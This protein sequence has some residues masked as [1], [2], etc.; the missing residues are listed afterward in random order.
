MTRE[1]CAA[2]VPEVSDWQE[3]LD[4]AMESRA[5]SGGAL[6][7]RPGFTAQYINSLRKK[8]RGGRLPLETAQRL[9]QSLG[10]TLEWLTRGEGTKE[11]PRQSDV[12]PVHRPVETP[13]PERYPSRGEVIALLANLVEPEVLVALRAAPVETEADPGREYWV[14]YAKDLR[15]L[16]HRI[17]ADPAFLPAEDEPA[18]SERAASDAPRRAPRRAPRS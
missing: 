11:A 7:R 17:K 4:E 8:G 2:R 14:A 10:V 18:E 12:Y 3:R 1:A 15:K 13:D 16:F 6:A 9:A 5:M